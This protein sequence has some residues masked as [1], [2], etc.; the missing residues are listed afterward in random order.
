MGEREQGPCGRQAA[1]D[2]RDAGGTE[3]AMKKIIW[4]IILLLV[5]GL[6]I[7]GCMLLNWNS[8]P[9]TAPPPSDTVKRGNIRV[10]VS[11]N[12]LVASNKDVDIRC[13]ASGEI[14]ELPYDVSNLVEPKA[15]VVRLDTADED[16]SLAQAKAQVDSDKAGVKQSELNW[17]IGKDN[18]VTTRQKVEATL[19]SCKVKLADARAK[20]KR[21]QEL[22]E[23]KLASNEDLETAN[24]VA[25]AADA[26]ETSAEV[27]VREL[28]QMSS[29]NDAKE[30]S[31]IAARAQLAQDQARMELAQQ[32]VDYCKVY[33]P[34][35]DDPKDPA[36]WMVSSLGTGV[37]KG[38]LV[39]SGTGGSS[40]GTTVMTLSDISHIYVLAAVDESDIGSVQDRFVR[41]QNLA[42]TITADA[43][44]DSDRNPNHKFE[45][46]VIRIGKGTV[47]SNVTTF[48]VKI[49]VTSPN[50]YILRPNMTATCNILLAE[51][52][53]V[54]T[55]SSQALNPKTG[56]GGRNATQPGTQPATAT[57]RIDDTT[58]RPTEALVSFARPDAPASTEPATEPATRNSANF[59]AVERAAYGR[60]P[61][62]PT[63]A[64]VTLLKPDGSSEVHDVVV[65]ITDGAT[66]EVISGLK[67]GDTVLLNRGGDSKWRNAQSQARMLMGGGGGRGR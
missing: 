51:K 32:Q 55:V 65:G 28:D 67:E 57:A 53:D 33:A 12:G 16:R 13:R 58:P 31:L 1:A 46:K 11:A 66:I 34:D 49:E 54:L 3:D 5:V 22:F 37:A 18:L 63:P 25:V 45:G 47:T 27:A 44:G 43:Y 24:T 30:Q 20:A 64:T 39:Q 48:E 26:D 19:A 21:T 15:L 35:S 23:Q 38:Y 59:I 62:R 6:G 52:Q 2:R 36:H 7:G 40:G 14:V 29:A 9:T 56:K 8:K 50:R 4:L 61:D 41:G 17:Q 60:N 10:E 42:V